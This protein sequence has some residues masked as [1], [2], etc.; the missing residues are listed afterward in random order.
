VEQIRDFLELDSLGYLSM[1]NL[2]KATCISREDL[3]FACF[4]GNYPVPIDESFHKFCL[5]QE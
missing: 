1:E 4:D 3:C 2:V 5:E